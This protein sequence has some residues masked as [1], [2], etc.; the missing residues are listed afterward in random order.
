ME[1]R[2]RPGADKEPSTIEDSAP[3]P[4]LPRQNGT[5]VQKEEKVYS[6]NLDLEVGIMWNY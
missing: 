6:E 4:S 5:E 1:E 3:T 2:V